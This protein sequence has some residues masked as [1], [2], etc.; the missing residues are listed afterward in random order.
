MGRENFHR[1]DSIETRIPRAIDLAHA[2]ST[3][4]RLDL[5]GT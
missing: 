3:E 5:V 2:A 1:D 4:R